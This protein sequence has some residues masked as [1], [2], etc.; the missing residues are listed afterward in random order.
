YA[1][2]ETPLLVQAHQLGMPC[3]GGLSMLIHQAALAFGLWTGIGDGV[4]E[5]MRKTVAERACEWK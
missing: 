3:A 1:P 4:C 2:V 5:V